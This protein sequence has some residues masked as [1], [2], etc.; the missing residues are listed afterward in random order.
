MIE[1]YRARK[2]EPGDFEAFD[3]ILALDHEHLQ[4]LRRMAPDGARAEVALFLPY[5]GHPTV[6]EVPDPYYG[7]AHH[8]EYVLD[9][10]ES[11]VKPLVETLQQKL[12]STTYTVG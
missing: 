3:L 2:V 8:F 5:A 6:S 9:L 10:I 11:G 1:G 7:E 4:H 12:A